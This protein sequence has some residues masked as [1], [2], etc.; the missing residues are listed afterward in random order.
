[1]GFQRVGRGKLFCFYF[2]TGV[3]FNP[4]EFTIC[5]DERESCPYNWVILMIKGIMKTECWHLKPV[6]SDFLTKFKSGIW[7]RV[8]PKVLQFF[9]VN[10]TPSLTLCIN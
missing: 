6:Q 9:E 7:C 10:P 4:K 8:W 1:M 2:I 5:F 3:C